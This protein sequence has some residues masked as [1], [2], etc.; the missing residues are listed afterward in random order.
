MLLGSISNTAWSLSTNYNSTCDPCNPSLESVEDFS[1]AKI[2][3]T[4]LSSIV[5]F[6]LCFLVV[7]SLNETYISLFYRSY[8]FLSLSFHVFYFPLSTF[9]F[10]LFLHIL[11][12]LFRLLS[13]F[14]YH[15]LSFLLSS[16]FLLRLSLFI[17]CFLFLFLSLSLSVFYFASWLPSLF[18]FACLLLYLPYSSLFIFACMFFI[19]II[20]VLS[21]V[22]VISTFQF[23]ICF[24]LLIF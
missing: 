1:P 10:C 18:F 5:F 24:F 11:Y 20:I 2:Y 19:I 3:R 6:L 21:F 9:F 7:F 4:N 13:L 12:S 15:L 17:L 22:S 23:L 16:I 14:F 8:S